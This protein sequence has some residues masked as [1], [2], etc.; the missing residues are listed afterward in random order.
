MRLAWV[1]ALIKGPK[2]LRTGKKKTN[3]TSHDLILHQNLN[4]GYVP[5]DYFARNNRQKLG[6]L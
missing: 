4:D 5:V 1:T 3:H 2:K 6:W